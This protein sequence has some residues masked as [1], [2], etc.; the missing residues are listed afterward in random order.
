MGLLLGSFADK[1][2][3]ESAEFQSYYAT[4][5]ARPARFWRAACKMAFAAP[6]SLRSQRPGM[7][8]SCITLGLIALHDGSTV[9]TSKTHSYQDELQLL[10]AWIRETS[11]HTTGVDGKVVS[12]IDEIF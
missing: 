9:V 4:S 2:L 1:Y 12:A 5:H 7:P 10:H 6:T 11:V 3:A 8:A